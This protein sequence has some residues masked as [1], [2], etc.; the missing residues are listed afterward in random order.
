M[1][2]ME[3]SLPAVTGDHYHVQTRQR[4]GLLTVGWNDSP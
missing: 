3:I 1:G 2:E 4:E